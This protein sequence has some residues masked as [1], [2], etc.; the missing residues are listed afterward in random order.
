MEVLL[1]LLL[2]AAGIVKAQTCEFAPVGAEWH[3]DYI[4]LFSVGF[5]NVKA[6]KDTI[7]DGISCTKLEKRQVGYEG[8]PWIPDPGLW[9]RNLG[10]EYVA[11]SGSVV[12][13]YRNERFNKWF[14]F[15][16][17]IGDSWPI[18]PPYNIGDM[19]S[20]TAGFLIVEGKGIQSINGMELRYIDIIDRE[21]SEWGY[22]DYLYGQQ[23][24][25]VRVFERLGPIDCYL[26]PE[27]HWTA[28]ANEGGFLR[29]YEDDLFG[30]FS[31]ISFNCDYINPEY[32]NIEEE[33]NPCFD[34]FPNPFLEQV[35]VQCDDNGI[36]MIKVYNSLG[37]LIEEKVSTDNDIPINLSAYPRG[38]Y[39]VT[40][41]SEKNNYYRMAIK[42]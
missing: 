3:Y 5:V 37:Q 35:L 36:K 7:I 23:A 8:N 39:H 1:M 10:S 2:A 20:D 27:T 6:I 11:C 34:V 31:T 32:Q 42:N 21:D 19:Q 18:P 12:Y 40:L 41:I 15:D 17:E 9:S 30:H 14:D 16:A 22:G 33:T 29:C 25:I 4:N 38:F 13:L 24:Y 26:F 28:D